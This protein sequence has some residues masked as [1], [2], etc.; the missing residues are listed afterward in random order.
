ML[1]PFSLILA[2][3]LI[4]ALLPASAAA[5]EIYKW[6]DENGVVHYSESR[7][8]KPAVPVETLYIE[9]TNPPGFDPADYYWSITNQAERISEEWSAIQ[10]Q[11]A[12]DEALE[13][14]IA[15]EEHVAELERQ[16]AADDEHA[17]A[18]YR[19]VYRPLALFPK[20]HPRFFSRGF[21]PGFHDDRHR[22]PPHHDRDRR[23]PPDPGPRPG[24]SPPKAPVTPATPGFRSGGR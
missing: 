21:H 3:S 19:P 10:E 17:Y 22:P 18:M 23:D 9:S 7:P 12:E 16:L 1:Q 24:W 6:V 13:R 11:R 2:V 5:F 14:A 20:R 15:A 8:E 4:A